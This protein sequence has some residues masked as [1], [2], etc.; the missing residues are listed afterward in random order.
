MMQESPQFLASCTCL[1]LVLWQGGAYG[2]GR[3]SPTSR[4]GEITISDWRAD[5]I[6]ISD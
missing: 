3:Y 6:T 1:H 2:F 5:E 4:D